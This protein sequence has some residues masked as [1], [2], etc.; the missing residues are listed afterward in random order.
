MRCKNTDTQSLPPLV[1]A[2]FIFSADLHSR[3]PHFSRLVVEATEKPE[4]GNEPVSRIR[5]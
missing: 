3:E 1:R 2:L 5:H 4:D